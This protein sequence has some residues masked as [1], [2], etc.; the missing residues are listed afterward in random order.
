M[1]KWC[2]IDVIFMEFRIFC[3]LRRGVS[4][5]VIV[6]FRVLLIGFLEMCEYCFIS[7]ILIL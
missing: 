5:I 7:V 4:I 2:F 6:I 3:M 1:I